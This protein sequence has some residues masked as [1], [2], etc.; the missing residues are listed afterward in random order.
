M[1]ENC[2]QVIMEEF[3]GEAF[4]EMNADTMEELQTSGRGDDE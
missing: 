1:C 3:A 2:N 4:N